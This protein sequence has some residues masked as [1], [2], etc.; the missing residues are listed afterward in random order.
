MYSLVQ[1]DFSSVYAD[2]GFEVRIALQDK[3]SSEVERCGTRKLCEAD[4]V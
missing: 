2:E 1:C 4:N 3:V